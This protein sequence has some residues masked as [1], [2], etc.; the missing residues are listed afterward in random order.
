[1]IKYLTSWYNNLK[2]PPKLNYIKSNITYLELDVYA[3]DKLKPFNF[4]CDLSNRITHIYIPIKILDDKLDDIEFSVDI[5]NIHELLLYQNATK[6]YYK[7][8]NQS[9]DLNFYK[10]YC[11]D[12]VSNEKSLIKTKEYNL[13]SIN[14]KN[15]DVIIN[16]NNKNLNLYSNVDVNLVKDILSHVLN[17]EEL[18]NI[19]SHIN[20][21]K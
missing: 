13:F 9:K 20:S 19:I 1:M 8:P 18:N 11:L 2:S 12:F 10:N 4:G 14:Y 5:S 17:S 3:S 16:L 6:Y 15:K 21:Y 7:L